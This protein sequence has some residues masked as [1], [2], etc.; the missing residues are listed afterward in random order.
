MGPFG[1]NFGVYTIRDEE[2]TVGTPPA[3][4]FTAGEYITFNPGTVISL[5]NYTV[6]PCMNA[7]PFNA[8]IPSDDYSTVAATMVALPVR[9]SAFE[10]TP[11]DRRVQLFWQ[12]ESE[13]QNQRFF[14][15]RS[16]DGAEWERLGEVAGAGHSSEARRYGLTDDAPI[17]GMA[18]YRLRQEDTNGAI[19]E[20]GMLSVT[21]DPQG[22]DLKV[23]P[24]PAEDQLTLETDH[25]PEGQVGIVLRNSLG[26]E[27][28][29]YEFVGTNTFRMDVSDLKRGLYFAELSN[30]H[31]LVTRSFLLR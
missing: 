2:L 5:A 6:I 30:G 13:S 28:A 3:V 8:F 29:R 25:L 14:I 23:W 15:D 21:F 26:Q 9:L 31:N 10:A 7:G 17:R 24:N 12:T 4:A 27:V 11:T 20:S 19:T 16:V 1:I 22:M 18:W